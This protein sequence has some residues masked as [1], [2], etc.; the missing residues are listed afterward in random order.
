MQYGAYSSS[1]GSTIAPSKKHLD[2]L[3]PFTLQ[4]RRCPTVCCANAIVIARILSLLQRGGGPCG[5]P[6]ACLSR[7]RR[8]CGEACCNRRRTTFGGRNCGCNA[9]PPALLQRRPA[10]RKKSAGARETQA[11]AVRRQLCLVV[12]FFY[13]VRIISEHVLR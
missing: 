2:G 12:G 8:R 13:R 7:R 3:G 9:V 1:T 4:L 11:A 10:K 5:R 6:R